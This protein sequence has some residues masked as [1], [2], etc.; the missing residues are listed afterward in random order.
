MISFSFSFMNLLIVVTQKYILWWKYKIHHEAPST[1]SVPDSC[2]SVQIF[3][4][5]YNVWVWLIPTCDVFVFAMLLFVCV[6]KW[7]RRVCAC[8]CRCLWRMEQVLQAAVIHPTW[9]WEPNLPDLVQFLWNS[10]LHIKTILWTFPFLLVFR[11]LINIFWSMSLLF[12]ETPAP[13][14]YSLRVMILV[15]ILVGAGQERGTS[16]LYSFQVKSRPPTMHNGSP[17]LT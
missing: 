11:N 17:S 7:H 9:V 15:L 2:T 10:A 14:V 4:E 5:V 3:T 1:A 16:F 13:Q 6:F 8:E 12:Q